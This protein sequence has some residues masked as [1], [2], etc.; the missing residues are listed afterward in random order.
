MVSPGMGRRSVPGP[1]GEEVDVDVEAGGG[2][3]DMTSCSV[4]GNMFCEGM[5]WNVES[6]WDTGGTGTVSLT[7]SASSSEASCSPSGSAST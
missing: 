1:D 2:R 7:S 4:R 3:S 5:G 6:G